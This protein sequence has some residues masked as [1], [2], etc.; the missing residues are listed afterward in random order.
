MKKA[1]KTKRTIIEKS[2]RLFNQK[3]YAGTSIQEIAKVAGVTK[4][5]IYGNNF[6]TKDEIAL[7]VFSYS[8][9]LLFGEL[10]ESVNQQESALAKL[11]AYCNFHRNNY[12]KILDYGGCPVLNGAI[13]TD[14]TH[15]ILNQKVAQSLKNWETSLVQIM[16]LG[17]EQK[18]FKTDTDTIYFAGLFLS[19]VEG[20]MV[21][22]K[23]HKESKYIL[24]ALTHIEELIKTFDIK[25]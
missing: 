17:I 15:P 6:H 8:V 4:G 1:E 11:K 3:G 13:D 12:Q 14:D 22:A 24:N 25:G 19:L 2:A 18:E 23:T 16:E 7:A 10:W 5:S 9:E 21:L 20:S